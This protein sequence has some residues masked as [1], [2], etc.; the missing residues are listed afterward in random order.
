MQL[1]NGS[2]G[3]VCDDGFDAR[4]ARVVCRQLGFTGGKLREQEYWFGSNLGLGIAMDNTACNGNEA[5]L[6]LCNFTTVHNCGH[7]EDIGISCDLPGRR[8]HGGMA[9]RKARCISC[10]SQPFPQPTAEIVSTRLANGTNSTSGRLEVQRRDG[11]WGTVCGKSGFGKAAAQSS[12]MQAAW[13]CWG[14]SGVPI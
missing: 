4:A 1:R 13:P 9:Q 12:G 3:T 6:G 14:R 2:W 7:S 10:C 5:A 8:R 11:T